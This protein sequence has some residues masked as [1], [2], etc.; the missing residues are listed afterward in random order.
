MVS[1]YDREASKV[2]RMHFLDPVKFYGD[3]FD[4]HGIG[5]IFRS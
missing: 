3:D 1:I 4:N 2:Y 5:L